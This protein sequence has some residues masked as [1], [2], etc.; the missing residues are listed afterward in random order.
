MS[1][2]TSVTTEFVDRD[3]L[4]QALKEMGFTNVEVHD[5]VGVKLRGGYGDRRANIVL[6]AHANKVNFYADCGFKL[7]EKKKQYEFIGDSMD[8]NAKRMNLDRLKQLYAEQRLVKEARRRGFR[9]LK[10]MEKSGK[11]LMTLRRS[12]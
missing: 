1:H 2:Y 9:V 12:F 11:I 7:D 5:G 4:I 8:L 10:R 6:R 3:C